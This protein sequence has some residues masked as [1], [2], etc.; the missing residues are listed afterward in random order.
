MVSH[1][2][3]SALCNGRA[4][5]WHRSGPRSDRTNLRGIGHYLVRIALTAM[6]NGG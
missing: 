6:P 1:A 4:N 3:T 2:T 5:P